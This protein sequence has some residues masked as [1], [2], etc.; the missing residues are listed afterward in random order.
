MLIVSVAFGSF[1]R[2]SPLF[3]IR[4][5][6]RRPPVILCA[7]GFFFVCDVSAFCGALREHY[8]PPSSPQTIRLYS[9]SLPTINSISA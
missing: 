5:S 7:L 1:A 6:R 3:D 2:G 4:S 9:P 8:T